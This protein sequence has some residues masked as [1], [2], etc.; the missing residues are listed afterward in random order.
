MKGMMEMEYVN[1]DA[2]VVGV[3]DKLMFKRLGYMHSKDQGTFFVFCYI[4]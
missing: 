2:V 1:I 3:V 4:R